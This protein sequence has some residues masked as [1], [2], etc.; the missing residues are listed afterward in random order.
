MNTTK[1]THILQ[2]LGQLSFVPK[3]HPILKKL[4][5]SSRKR[6]LD[7]SNFMRGWQPM[8]DKSLE[9]QLGLQ[10][11]KTWHNASKP[12]YLLLSKRGMHMLKLV[13]FWVSL[14]TYS[15]ESPRDIVRSSLAHFGAT[16]QSLSHLLQRQSPQQGYRQQQPQN[17]SL[18]KQ[19]FFLKPQ[20]IEVPQTDEIQSGVRIIEQGQ[21]VIWK[22]DSKQLNLMRFGRRLQ[23]N[24]KHVL[25]EFKLLRFGQMASY[26]VSSNFLKIIRNSLADHQ[27]L[28]S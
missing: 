10:T 20:I 7:A 14:C 28:I 17:P 15:Q 24:R 12:R 21:E 22:T 4:K 16:H 23:F 5:L 9:V 2:L 1:H 11:L 13:S 27:L 3:H 18:S 8:L 19:P 6:T 26:T 25:K